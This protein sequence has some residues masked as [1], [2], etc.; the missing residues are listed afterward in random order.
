MVALPSLLQRFAF[1]IAYNVVAQQRTFLASWASETP[2]TS[3]GFSEILERQD[4]GYTKA[5]ECN[6][7]I[8]LAPREHSTWS[9]SGVARWKDDL[10]VP[11]W[12]IQWI[13]KSLVSRMWCSLL[14]FTLDGDQGSVCAQE[15][16]A[17][18]GQRSLHTRQP[19]ASYAMDQLD[20]VYED[21]VSMG[22]FKS[23]SLSIQARRR[24]KGGC[25][26]GDNLGHE[27][28]GH[29]QHTWDRPGGTVRCN[30]E[31][32]GECMY[33]R[34]ESSTRENGRPQSE[35]QAYPLT[36]L[37]GRQGQESTGFPPREDL[38]V[39]PGVEEI[40]EACR[41]E[42]QCPAY[43][44][45]DPKGRPH[46]AIQGKA[47][48][49]PPAQAG[50]AADGTAG[51]H[52]SRG[53][54][55]REGRRVQARLR[56]YGRPAGRRGLGGGRTQACKEGEKRGRGMRKGY[57]GKESSFETAPDLKACSMK[58]ACEKGDSN[59]EVTCDGGTGGNFTSSWFSAFGSF[60]WTSLPSLKS[61]IDLENGMKSFGGYESVRHNAYLCGL[62]GNNTN[63]IH[64]TGV[65]FGFTRDGGNVWEEVWNDE[66]FAFFLGIL[67]TAVLLGFLAIW[68][69]C[70]DL[71]KEDWRLNMKAEVEKRRI[72]CV[73][74]RRYTQK[75]TRRRES[76][77]IGR[78]FVCYLL[79]W[80]N[81][82]CLALNGLDAAVNE[83]WSTTF[84]FGDEG[85]GD[86]QGFGT[87]PVFQN[88]I[89]STWGNSTLVDS[90]VEMLTRSSLP[91]ES[92][93]IIETE[94]LMRSSTSRENL[95]EYGTEMLTWS[96]PPSTVGGGL[97]MGM[98]TRSS[99]L[100]SFSSWGLLEMLTRS[101][102]PPDTREGNGTE[103]L[104]RSPP[105]EVLEPPKPYDSAKVEMLTRSSP[106]RWLADLAM[107]QLPHNAGSG[108]ELQRRIEH[109]W[110]QFQEFHQEQRNMAE[111][112]T[113]VI[114][115]TLMSE[116]ALGLARQRAD[117]RVLFVMFGILEVQVRV[118]YV[119]V[120]AFDAV[121]FVDVVVQL[122][123]PW[124]NDRRD[125]DMELIYVDPQ[126]LPHALDGMDAIS[127]I[128]DLWSAHE[129]IPILITTTLV[130]EDGETTHDTAAHRMNSL[131]TCNDV[132]RTTG[133]EMICQRNAV[134]SCSVGFRR[135]G[136]ILPVD[137][138]IGAYVTLLIQ[139]GGAGCGNGWDSMSMSVIDS[140]ES[141][142]MQSEEPLRKGRR[143]CTPR[144]E[145]QWIYAYCLGWSQ[146]L[147]MWRGAAGGRPMQRFV[148]SQ[149]APYERVPSEDLAVYKVFPQP[150]A[151]QD[152]DIE[153]F[154][155]G[156]R[157][158]IE[159]QFTL[160]LASIDWRQRSTGETG[161]TPITLETWKS[162]KKVE[163]HLDRR[164]LIEQIGMTPWCERQELPCDLTVRGIPWRATDSGLRRI[165]EGDL[166]NLVATI[167]WPEIP[168]LV[169]WR[170]VQEGCLITDIPS[171][172]RRPTVTEDG[173]GATGDGGTGGNAT[174]L[175]LDEG[176]TSTL[177]QNVKRSA[178][179]YS[180]RVGT[181]E[182]EVDKFE[183]EDLHAPK[184]AIDRAL[185]TRNHEWRENPG[186]IFYVSPQPA[187]LMR[188]G[189]TAYLLAD[190]DMVGGGTS[191]VM[192]DVEVISGPWNPENP[193]VHPGDE[194]REVALIT[195]T[196][197]RN[198][199]IVKMELE[200]FCHGGNV[201]CEIFHSGEIWEVDDRSE[202]FLAC[203]DY[204][205]VSV[206][207]IVERMAICTLPAQASHQTSMHDRDDDEHENDP[208]DEDMKEHEGFA[209]LQHT[210]RSTNGENLRKI[211]HN[212]VVGNS[213]TWRPSYTRAAWFRL[214]PPGNGTKRVTFSHFVEDDGGSC[215][216]DLA[217][218]NGFVS[219]FCHRPHYVDSSE[220]FENLCT[221]LRRGDVL[222]DAALPITE[223]PYGVLP[224][225]EEATS[226]GSQEHSYDFSQGRND[227]T[228]EDTWTMKG[229]D[230]R[231]VWELRVW[232][233]NHCT[234][235]YF[236]LDE[237]SWHPV[238]LRW[239]H[240]PVWCFQQPLELHFYVDGSTD[241]HGNG[242]ACVLFVL[243][244]FGWYFGGFVTNRTTSHGDSFQAEMEGNLLASKWAF[245]LLKLLG[246]NGLALPEIF[247]H[248]D[249]ASAAK[250]VGGEWR[251]NL[252][253]SLYKAARSIHHI[254]W[255]SYGKKFNI[256][257]EK[258]HSGNPGN[259]AA[260]SAAAAAMRF[261]KE[262]TFLNVLV[263][264]S[265]AK[266]AC[267]LWLLY[268]ADLEDFWRDGHLLLPRPVARFDKEVA[269]EL[270][271]T[272]NKQGQDRQV[273]LELNL[274]SCNVMT[275]GE[276]NPRRGPVGEVESI[277]RQG[278]EGGYHVLALQETRMRRCVPKTN[279]WYYCFSSPPSKK[280][281]GGIL[282]AFRK[283][284]KFGTTADGKAL[285]WKEEN[286][287]L[288]FSNERCL[289]LRLAHPA[290]NAIF[291][292]GHAPHTGNEQHIID[293]W[294]D[295]LWKAIPS[296]HRALPVFFL[297]DA[298]AKVGNLTSR[299]VHD[300]GAEEQ[301]VG[302]DAFHHFLEKAD[303][304]LPA[305]WNE[306]H[307]GPH[308]TWLHPNGSASRIDFI[309][310][311]TE[312]KDATASSRVSDHL[313]VS[314]KLWDHRP[315][316]VRVKKLHHFED[317][318]KGWKV[319]REQVSCGKLSGR[320]WWNLQDELRRMP[321]GS[322]HLDVHRHTLNLQK[323][324]YGITKAY[325]G[326]KSGP[327]KDYLDEDTWFQV[328][329][330]K[331]AKKRFFTAREHLRLRWLGGLFHAWKHGEECDLKEVDAKCKEMALAERDYKKASILAQQMIRKADESFF[332]QFSKKLEACDS[333]RHQRQ[334]WKEVKRYLPKYK[335]KKKVLNAQNRDV[336][337]DKWA[338]Y[339]CG[340]EAGTVSSPEETYANC[341]KKQNLQQPC[342]P[343]R[344][345]LPSL[346]ELEFY[347]KSTNPN[348]CGGP[349]GIGPDVIKHMSD[350]LA[351][352]L[353]DIALKQLCWQSEPVFWKGGILRMIPK[354]TGLETT[355]E[356]FRG[357]M[358][359]SVLGKKI[360]A[361]LR[362][363]IVKHI[364]PFRPRGQLG[365]YPHMEA[366]FGSHL[367][368]TS[369]RIA[370][371]VR[372]PTAVIFVDLSTAYHSLVRQLLTGTSKFDFEE[373]QFVQKQLREKGQEVDL[374]NMKL[375]HDGH[376]QSIGTPDFI[377]KNVQECNSSTWSSLEGNWISTRKGSRPGSPLADVSF[378][379]AMEEV[380][381]RLEEALQEDPHIVN[382]AKEIGIPN[383]PILWAD[384]IALIIP[385]CDNRELQRAAGD[386]MEKTHKVLTDRGFTINYAHNK[387]EV[388]FSFC[389]QGAKQCRVELLE[390]NDPVHCFGS[391]SDVKTLKVKGK[392][393]HLGSVLSGGGSIEE[394]IAQRVG[395]AWQAFRGLR[396][397]LCRSSLKVETRLRLFKTLVMTKLLF[398]SGSWPLV[399]LRQ[400]ERLTK[401]YL[402][403]V[404]QIVGQYYQKGKKEQ[405]WSNRRVLAVHQLPEMRVLLAKERLT[406]A[407][408]L[409]LHGGA[410]LNALVVRE[411]EVRKDSWLHGCLAD[412]SWLNEV[413]GNSWGS[414]WDQLCCAW[415]S[416]K[417]G[418]KAFVRS[419]VQ[420]HVLQ[421]T[422]AFER[423]GTRDVT[424]THGSCEW[425]CWCGDAFL[426]K[427]ALRV[428][429]WAKHQETSLEHRL[430]TGTVCP[431]CLTQYWTVGR[432]RQH[433]QYMS[434][435]GE[436]NR[437]YS[438]LTVMGH[439]RS[440]GLATAGKL[441]LDGWRRR[442]AIK[443]HGPL[444][445][446]AV[447]EHSTWALREIDKIEKT[448]NNTLLA[449]PYSWLCE[450]ILNKISQT[451]REDESTW[452]EVAIGC[453]D[454]DLC[455]E[456]VVVVNVLFAGMR[457]TWANQ[458]EKDDW[459]SFLLG[460]NGGEAL[461]E[462]FHARLLYGIAESVDGL[463]P[464]RPIAP[465]TAN[466]GERN[467]TY[468]AIS[469]SI[470]LCK[471][472]EDL[473]KPGVRLAELRKFL[474]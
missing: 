296:N 416:K 223:E 76:V 398:G 9:T 182:P 331:E 344:D 80:E 418:W 435:T 377:V 112:Y 138:E 122:R 422:I 350:P 175:P 458:Q 340:M 417:G 78:L 163:Y 456:E 446:G 407:K 402:G 473:R 234:L 368:R 434:R 84:E 375:V 120:S 341:L 260:D 86:S 455:S 258:G 1:L 96:S 467:K 64:Q 20:T 50:D 43:K 449:E 266:C 199:F 71:L 216:I 232:F 300:A 360:Q 155:L 3:K 116:E 353:W 293:Q 193:Q 329:V 125:L 393:R 427:K 259:E 255:Q 93:T 401:C 48:D 362:R 227:G 272:K 297:G 18:G 358:L 332:E 251:G 298:N 156:K 335:S 320:D 222:E 404:R 147:R 411:W 397:L 104:T 77:G 342:R 190:Q 207:P 444:P 295:T 152:A 254:L 158:D 387:T 338:P 339:L 66:V 262:E 420:R 74:R 168:L 466:V 447:P 176:D 315:V 317:P 67:L 142:F 238:A 233:E 28:K 457:H 452:F 113:R 57:E 303:V 189:A 166:V 133:M 58:D 389:G 245:D 7:S 128:M 355:P 185:R 390:M 460:S 432:L 311:P 191:I 159:A 351:P 59:N 123:R 263:Q 419:G 357:I 139:F 186:R 349:D 46:Q 307:S 366:M 220:F 203:G 469:R 250:M 209:L 424:F 201:R 461:L 248:Y 53:C 327:R 406:Y 30:S 290:L 247:I 114:K 442:E 202:H 459:N 100:P 65:S 246:W 39:G 68:W 204:L 165:I 361:A 305:T 319:G 464:H 282:L 198:D 314:Q 288:I 437:C 217:V 322:W 200:N 181:E 45:C 309:G 170:M 79:L 206:K 364:M 318:K 345:E 396:F 42:G 55:S 356:K 277:L 268:R 11:M 131:A 413:N 299:F 52:G 121:D 408:R 239:L 169:Q 313:C 354:G 328:C 160:V 51:R 275:L 308:H 188:H 16:G 63:S 399:S 195:A 167:P 450:G 19:A 92:G 400:N 10:A 34:D 161:T 89:E 95:V 119:W 33:A 423:E 157:H 228:Y 130:M 208:D 359:T 162:A 433:L 370:S 110:G 242:S 244:H 171:M 69:E 440:D 213:S 428:H 81:F 153:S 415:Q 369:L 381:Y 430:V 40:P 73:C 90:G 280:G 468:S 143:L 333:A 240:L 291:V 325:M 179:F 323:R 436:A 267:W 151:A 212:L 27:G 215:H 83:N 172:T 304:W 88:G 196:I 177:M 269:K 438:F 109:T 54:G 443:C 178:C 281:Q 62:D 214:P 149:V 326:Q 101:S 285:V 336:L 243:T 257:H 32:I 451:L 235:P 24:A 453:L 35:T 187:D 236:S 21:A 388:L 346:I 462:W 301:N 134:C 137:L 98:L 310:L 256:I 23:P 253:S 365:G 150:G 474:H 136:D 294:W 108:T 392:Y 229:I 347:M 264:D 330:K 465:R 99:F 205:I 403:M 343:V 380:G 378:M 111:R 97:G 146:P 115:Q 289:I 237:I 395:M 72:V 26:E 276:N 273:K 270:G 470:L 371:G 118:E 103:V 15:E 279:A 13:E 211:K 117:G 278:A 94:M 192:V 61:P 12:S 252:D 271:S 225:F 127:V 49:L 22:S 218:S 431:A 394:E 221:E 4:Q 439:D 226:N 445:F 102:S 249:N 410:E 5:Q 405:V 448:L 164:S 302:G 2:T 429:G 31:G 372:K 385:A 463:K 44:L 38:E 129:R 391:G 41:G 373:L 426:T 145:I 414:D 85:E 106:T 197:N 230:M 29:D 384:D 283:N 126:P 37:K 316:E 287:K 56:G 324:L 105:L 379:I 173:E 409:F 174:A 25:T 367:A 60:W 14:Q 148:A 70:Y 306:C 231:D 135:F 374:T 144:G 321:L 265:V 376:L 6:R 184:R 284:E 132:Q 471:D 312:W 241:G 334:M 363:N 194:W 337:E 425:R 261:G 47:G 210:R 348:R 140:D 274:A 421:E 454:E 82:G 441:P 154:V 219:D 386:I 36:S 180:Y 472:L 17:K 383:M 286:F 412:L 75:I 124:E 87:G 91:V 352:H 382:A 183:G 292:C 141:I 224:I 8:A 107:G